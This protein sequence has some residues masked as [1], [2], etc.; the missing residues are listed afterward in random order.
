[1]SILLDAGPSLNFL[2]VGQ[3]KILIQAAKAHNLQLA[4]PE[5]VDVEVEGKTN[6]RRFERTGVL[7]TWR[8]LKSSHRLLIL[9]DSLTDTD[10]SD[11]VAR[12]SGMPAAARVAQRR[13]LGEIMVLAHASI[14]VREARTSSSCWTTVTPAAAPEPS[15]SGSNVAKLPDACSCGVPPSSCA[16]HPP[17]MDGSSATS[18]TRPSTPR[19]ARSTTACRPCHASG[20]QFPTY[21][22]RRP[23]TPDRAP[24]P[25]GR[26]GAGARVRRALDRA[27][28]R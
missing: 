4:A 17:R 14:R 8:T 1:M 9:D 19:C 5:R 13:S 15:A 7:N 20:A 28:R 10:F 24:C 18:P 27:F 22:P 2:A 26:S 6:D 21:N 3:Q 25:L 16:R 23:H 12:I 11:A